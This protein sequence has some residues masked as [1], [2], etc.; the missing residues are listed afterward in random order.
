MCNKSKFTVLIAK[1][2]TREKE[3]ESKSMISCRF[4]ASCLRD[5]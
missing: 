4:D 2:E 5:V 1:R 3:G